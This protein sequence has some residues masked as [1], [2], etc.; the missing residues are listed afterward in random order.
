MYLENEESLKGTGGK[1]KMPVSKKRKKKAPVV[2]QGKTG[3]NSA[4]IRYICTNC[5]ADEEIP[6]DVVK[7][8]DEMDQSNINEPPQFNCELCGGLM[9]PERYISV[10]GKVFEYKKDSD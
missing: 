6:L 5:G 9:R 7:T 8:F 3:Q 2:Q 4:M 1:V 10:F